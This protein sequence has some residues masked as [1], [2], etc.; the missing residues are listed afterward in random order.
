MKWAVVLA[1]V[2]LAGCG[3]VTD[4]TSPWQIVQDRL[5]A[6]PPAAGT[7]AAALRAALTP[8][9]L[10]Q[11]EGPVLLVQ[12]PLRGT[13]AVMTRVASNQGVD[14]YMSGDS[15]SISLREGVLVATRGM[16]FDLMIADIRAAAPAI[17][18]GSGRATRIHRYLDGEDHGR[19]VRYD[20]L[21]RQENGLITEHCDG[22]G[23]TFRN[24]YAATVSM[25]WVSPRNGSLIIEWLKR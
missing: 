1:L 21:Y 17:A 12:V 11:I 25:Q 10:A 16:G 5:T 3:S 19:A 13:V 9:A 24:T 22:D 8:D 6:E 14:T 18:A 4:R 23:Q 2:W 7:S 15:I 20:C